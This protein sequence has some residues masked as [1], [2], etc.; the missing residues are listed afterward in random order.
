MDRAVGSKDLDRTLRLLAG[1]R[2]PGFCSSVLN[3]AY[4][5]PNVEILY[6]AVH[7]GPGLCRQ[8]PYLVNFLRCSRIEVGGPWPLVR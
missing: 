4:K 5:I 7:S 3:G 8:R 6:A 2:N 1:I